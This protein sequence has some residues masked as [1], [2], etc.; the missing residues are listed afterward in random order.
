MR[1]FEGRLS[2]L[3][4]ETAAF[5]EMEREARASERTARDE[6]H[7]DETDRETDRETEKYYLC[8]FTRISLA[9]RSQ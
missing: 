5:L 4:E 3:E 1:S 8:C 7:G 6:R 2:T 9:R